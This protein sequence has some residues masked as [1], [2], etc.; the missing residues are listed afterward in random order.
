[1]LIAN[2]SVLGTG[3][4]IAFANAIIHYDRSFNFTENKQSDGRMERIGLNEEATIYNLIVANSLEIHL[5]KSLENK[6]LVD[7]LFLKTGYLTK[8]RIKDIFNPK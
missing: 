2:P 6:Q 5:E 3:V 8:E 1:M 7:E 4:N